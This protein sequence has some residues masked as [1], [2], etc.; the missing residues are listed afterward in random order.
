[1]IAA[2]AARV[3]VIIS[4]DTSNASLMREAARLGA[5]MIND[6]RALQREGALQA[7]RETG[8]AVCLMHMQGEPG[9][10]QREPHYTDVVAEVCGFLAS[11]ALQCR[12]AGLCAGRLLI[13]PGFGFGK[14]VQH[15]L[16][17]FNGLP[18]LL[19]L[20]YPVLIGVSRKSMI[21]QVLGRPVRARLAG[22]LALATLGAKAGVG[23]VRTHDVAA[24]CDALAMVAAIR[25]GWSG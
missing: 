11:R 17:L 16:T 15:N 23:V 1:V 3:D 4:V 13:D 7:A 12:E 19:A 5:G 24:T 14:T 10:M 18:E 2:I 21:G 8:L 9:V 22:G 20:G 6:V 25:D